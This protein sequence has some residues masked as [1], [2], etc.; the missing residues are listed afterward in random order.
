VLSS[1]N[2]KVKG[3]GALVMRL[4]ARITTR[5]SSP[6]PRMCFSSILKIM[7][8]TQHQLIHISSTGKCDEYNDSLKGT[9][10][11]RIEEYIAYWRK[12]CY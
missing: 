11:V 7:H 3:S 10:C 12:Y 9:E 4:G 2:D 1:S 6:M 5:R 8:S